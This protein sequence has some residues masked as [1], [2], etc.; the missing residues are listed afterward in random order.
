MKRLILF[1]IILFT[2][3]SC[4]NI[5]DEPTKEVKFR[6]NRFGVEH[7]SLKSFDI[8]E[9]SH[10]HYP[11]KV[12]VYLTN[13]ESGITYTTISPNANIFFNEGTDPIN[14]P[15]GVYDCS[16]D[17]GGYPINNEAYS[18][19]YYIWSIK[20]T[21]ININDTT[22]LITFNLDKT[23]A[24][25][26]RDA[27][28]NIDYKAINSQ[29]DTLHWTGR[30]KYDFAYVT[31]WSYAGIYTNGYGN[32]VTVIFEAKKDNYYYFVIPDIDSSST[33]SNIIVPEFTGQEIKF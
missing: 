5:V 19:S 22:T 2:F 29:N 13:K 10:F 16:V 26:V 32:K 11:F 28:V 14:L 9:W 12:Y 8:N 20:D 4:K 21:T 17:G 24:L 1:L 6:A 18:A 3:L 23:P 15:Y 30:G 25:L 31:P 27:D 33:S 7:G